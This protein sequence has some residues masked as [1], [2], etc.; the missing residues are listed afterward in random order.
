MLELFYRNAPLPLCLLVR[1]TSATFITTT[2]TTSLPCAANVAFVENA[3][4]IRCR[5]KDAAR[6]NTGESQ[7]ND[8]ETKYYM[9]SKEYLYSEI[10]EKIRTILYCTIVCLNFEWV[11]YDDYTY[12]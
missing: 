4:T 1:P 3:V 2:T 12:T 6:A 9:H 7:N 11:Y 8:A 5:A 10:A